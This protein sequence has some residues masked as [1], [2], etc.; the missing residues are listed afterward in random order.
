MPED[1]FQK[2]LHEIVLLDE[3]RSICAAQPG[4]FASSTI[5]VWKTLH[6]AKSWPL[7]CISPEPASSALLHSEWL[8]RTHE[9]LN[10]WNSRNLQ[11]WSHIFKFLYITQF[12]YKRKLHNPRAS[13]IKVGSAI[14]INLRRHR[15]L[16]FHFITNSRV[17]IYTQSST[18]EDGNYRVVEV[19]IL[20]SGTKYQPKL[21]INIINQR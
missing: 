11:W 18:V 8:K 3:V 21:I 5:H 4:F 13:A 15:G 2:A 7:C 17:D 9:V 16:D 6:D 19:R 12:S 20:K 1:F 10:F 14:F